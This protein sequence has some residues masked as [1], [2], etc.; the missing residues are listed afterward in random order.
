MLTTIP[1]VK[2][3]RPADYHQVAFCQVAKNF[4]EVILRWIA[5]EADAFDAVV[6]NQINKRPV[7]QFTDRGRRNKQSRSIAI[8]RQLNLGETFRAAIFQPGCQHPIQACTSDGLKNWSLTSRAY[9][10]P[11]FCAPTKFQDDH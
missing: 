7:H 6:T 2:L 9:V 1:S 8:Y 5:H 10:G 4:D 11:Y 3:F